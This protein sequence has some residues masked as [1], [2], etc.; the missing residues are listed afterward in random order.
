MLETQSII[1]YNV[2][3][4]PDGGWFVSNPILVIATTMIL[5][6]PSISRF[7]CCPCYRILSTNLGHVPQPI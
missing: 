5:V 6:G 1:V 4:K 2:L 7:I 3:L